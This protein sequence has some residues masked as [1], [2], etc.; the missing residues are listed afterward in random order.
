MFTAVDDDPDTVE[1][2][3]AAGAN[4]FIVKKAGGLAELVRRITP[5][6]GRPEAATGPRDP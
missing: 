2:A 5:F 4:D 6:L 3:R 1:A